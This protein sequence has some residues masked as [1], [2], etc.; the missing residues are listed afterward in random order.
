VSAPLTVA[1]P[2]GEVSAVALVLHGGRSESTAPVRANQLAVLR[3]RPIAA[4]LH[5][6]GRTHGLA[7]ARLQFR[8]RG[9]NGA[10]RSPVGDALGALEDLAGRYP[11]RPIAVVG[12][13]MGGRTA[14]YVGGHAAVTTV[15]GLAPWIEPADPADGLAGRRVLI[16]HGDHD[17]MTSAVASH[18]F[19]ESLVG[20]A[21]SVGW[22]GVHGDGHAMLRR[23]RTWDELATGFVLASTAD[24]PP[25][26]TV[27]EDTAKVIEKALAT[28]TALAV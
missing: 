27:G 19:A 14:M 3:L 26:A 28:D 21:E 5:R 20:S 16:A 1:E 4:A 2:R 18:A 10:Q 23:P 25:G 9:W 22:V 7:V 12:H 15:V 8:V 13:S 11:G 17:R 24:V 6:A